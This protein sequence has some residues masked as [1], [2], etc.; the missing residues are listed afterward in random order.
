M[1]MLKFATAGLALLVMAGCASRA[2]IDMPIIQPVQSLAYE[3]KTFYPDIYYCQ[4]Q[5]NLFSG[6]ATQ[7]MRPLGSAKLP[8]ASSPPMKNFD[9]L[10][11]EQLPSTSMITHDVREKDYRLKV[12]IQAHENRGP[13]YLDYLMAKNLPMNLLT[14]GIA[15]ED[16]DVIADFEVVYSLYDKDDQLLYRKDYTVKDSVPHQTGNFDLGDRMLMPARDMMK[17]YLQ[18]TMNDFFIQASQPSLRHVAVV[19]SPAV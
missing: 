3:H 4:P 8:R 19:S 7:A 1:T 2:E 13:V 6:A 17:K 9:L 5:A 12:E 16:F 11:R 18:L 10:L 15:N 14:F